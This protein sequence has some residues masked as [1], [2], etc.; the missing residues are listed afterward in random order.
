MAVADGALDKQ[1]A[2]PGEPHTVSPQSQHEVQLVLLEVREHSDERGDEE[3]RPAPFV[4]VDKCRDTPTDVFHGRHSAGLFLLGKCG[5]SRA[6]FLVLLLNLLLHVILVVPV[7]RHH[8]RVRGDAGRRRRRRVA[9]AVARG[10]RV[11]RV[12]RVGVRVAGGVEVAEWAV[13]LCAPTH[14]VELAGHFLEV[15]TLTPCWSAPSPS[16]PCRLDMYVPAP[17]T[18]RTYPTL[19]PVPAN[20]WG[21]IHLF[22]RDTPP[23]ALLPTLHH[24]ERHAFPSSGRGYIPLWL[25][26]H[27]GLHCRR[28]LR[29]GLLRLR[30]LLESWPVDICLLLFNVVWKNHSL[31]L[32]VEAGC[33]S[34]RCPAE[35]EGVLR[36]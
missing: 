32:V 14:H 36:R 24:P 7:P 15:G 34:R 21:P 6:P 4:L 5:R 17:R 19:P 13:V 10:G 12:G 23:P 9:V 20:G 26:L 2:E 11:R 18:P 22:S 16:P 25:F 31:R 8:V 30:F 3:V 1:A 35:A 33:S 28:R 29:G 27:A